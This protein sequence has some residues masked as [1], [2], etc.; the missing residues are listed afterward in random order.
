MKRRL[1]DDQKKYLYLGIT[2]FVSL[3]LVMIVTSLFPKAGM[4]LSIINSIITALTPIWIGLIIAYLVNPIVKFFENT[5]FRKLK[6]TKK[7][8]ARGLS[9]TVSILLLLAIIVGLMVLVIPQLITTIAMLSKQ[10]P[11]YYHNIH[12]WA[13]NLAYENPSVGGWVL[14]FVEGAYEGVTDFV[15][16][17]FHDTNA[18]GAV[19]SSL[20]SVSGAFLN[21]FVGIIISIY[22]LCDKEN[23]LAQSRKLTASVFSEKWYTRLMMLCSE[24]HHV[25]GEFIT[26]KLIDSLFVGIVTFL[27]MWIVG[28]PYATLVAVLVAVMNLIPFFGQFLAIIPSALLILVIDPWKALI[29]VIG[30]VIFMQIDGNII[31]PKILG[32][33]IGLKSFWI[34]FAIIFFGGMF[35][36]VGMLIGV[37]VF[38]MFYRSITRYMD[39]HLRKKGLPT[40]AYAYAASS[41]SYPD[42]KTRRKLKKAEK[43]ERKK[44]TV[45]ES[46]TDVE[47]EK[48]EAEKTAYDEAE[49]EPQT[50][51][52]P[53]VEKDTEDNA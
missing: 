52:E 44:G 37:P 17:M 29:F 31:S 16:N 15:K 27:F 32:D 30:I 53:V 2:L 6:K 48:F 24:T 40:E 41:P 5:L 10:M 43:D 26:G 14:T 19:T 36:I 47:P 11:V 22:L 23:F 4:I 33:S 39:R 18:V 13:K 42:R 9:V 34:L 45:F 3:S 1:K 50:S 51:A 49:A 28:I 21:F 25:F 46:S 35:G 7:G 38:A 8:M 20:Q 12:D